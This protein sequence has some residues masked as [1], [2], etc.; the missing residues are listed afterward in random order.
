M[1][2]MCSG[3][4]P[5]APIP[6]DRMA[7]FMQPWVVLLFRESASK[8]SLLM[9]VVIIVILFVFVD[10]FSS[11]YLYLYLLKELFLTLIVV[12]MD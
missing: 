12:V 10:V 3:L 2:S 11:S 8:K 1:F 5:R 9:T 4:T 7:Q 6:D